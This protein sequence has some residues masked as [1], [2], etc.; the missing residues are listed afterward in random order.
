[1][2]IISY[3]KCY[4]SVLGNSQLSVVVVYSANMEIYDWYPLHFWVL[5]WHDEHNPSNVSKITWLR[6]HDQDH[7]TKNWLKKCIN[8]KMIKTYYVHMY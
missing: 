2:T 3:P 1:M 5:S 8:Y 7:M 4:T 6:S